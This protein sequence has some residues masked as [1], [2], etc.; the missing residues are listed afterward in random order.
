MKTNGIR[1]HEPGGSNVLR[2][3]EYEL[4]PVGAGQVLLRHTSVGLNYI[5]VYQRTGFYKMPL[6][7]VP[8]SEAAGVVEELGEGVTGAGGGGP[9]CVCRG[10]W[11][12]LRAPGGAGGPDGEAAAGCERPDGGGDDAAGHDGAVSD[13]ADL[14][15][16]AR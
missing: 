6:P 5:D 13:P 14:P 1:I 7:Y 11:C 12:V 3:E 16:A 15:G 2:W 9:G 8:G 4:P 10:A